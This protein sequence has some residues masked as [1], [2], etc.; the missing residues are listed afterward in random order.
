MLINKSDC[1]VE[2]YVG[3]DKL[4]ISYTIS[5]QKICDILFMNMFFCFALYRYIIRRRLNATFKKPHKTLYIRKTHLLLFPC[6]QVLW[7][8]NAYSFVSTYTCIYSY[9]YISVKNRK[10]F[11]GNCKNTSRKIQK[12]KR[13]PTSVYHI[14]WLLL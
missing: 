2:F 10:I 9:I 14:L 11:Y 12:N 5:C 3:I 1:Y 7:S 6:T 8:E 4:Y 13:Y